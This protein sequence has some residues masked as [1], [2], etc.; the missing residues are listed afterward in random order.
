MKQTKKA[1]IWQSIILGTILV[2]IFACIFI[3][4]ENISATEIIGKQQNYNIETEEPATIGIEQ[5][6]EK[7]IKLEGA[8]VLLQQKII[9]TSNKDSV[10]KEKLEIKVPDIQEKQPQKIVVLADGKRLST[11]NYNYD[12]EN[13]QLNIE[14]AK[15][16]KTYKII[17]TYPETEIK[18]EEIQLSTKAYIKVE[19]QEEIETKDEQ[20]VTI[21]ETG[22]VVSIEEKMTKETYKGYLYEAKENETI[23]GENYIIEVSN[24]QNE[25]EM[26]I[27]KEKEI[28]TYEEQGT[29]IENS[30]NQSTYFKQ[31]SINKE[32][33]IDILGDDRNNYNYKSTRRHT[34]R[35]YNKR[36][37][38]R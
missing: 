28:Y 34:N 31:T 5:D 18:Q 36:L 33:M 27:T 11:Q 26:E 19:N 8:E 35:N 4:K 10:D 37:N 38:R 7:Y 9:V 32:Q 30:T 14:T 6:I 2:A 1:L 15:K 24:T 29:K 21:Q 17:Y 25:E 13:K 12:A 16:I 20:T 3:K 22:E 23:Y